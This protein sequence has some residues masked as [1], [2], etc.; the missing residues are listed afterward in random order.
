MMQRQNFQYPILPGP[1]PGLNRTGN[2]GGNVFM[3]AYH[4]MTVFAYSAKTHVM[5]T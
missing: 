4:F 2:L 3:G 1:S 5:L